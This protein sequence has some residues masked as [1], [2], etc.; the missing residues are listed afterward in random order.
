[1]SSLKLVGRPADQARHVVT[2]LSVDTALADGVSQAY[3]QQKVSDGVAPLAT[4][5]YVDGQD[6]QF[7]TKTYVNTRD[8]LLLPTSQRGAANGVAP[9]DSQGKVLSS[10]LPTLGSGIIKG[11]YYPTSRSQ[12]TS[13]TQGA[14]KQMAAWSYPAPGFRWVPIVFGNAIVYNGDGRLDVEVRVG[15]ATNGLVI[16]AGQSQNVFNGYASVCIHPQGWNNSAGQGYAPT[17]VV[18]VTMWATNPFAGAAETVAPDYD[19]DNCLYLL[20]I[21]PN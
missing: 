19:Q 17:A 15:T 21:S 18:N 16:A 6:G 2:K 13:V 11:P 14:Y 20:K 5:T 12:A 3:V 10:Y 1:M 9:L 8:G 7:A 4:K